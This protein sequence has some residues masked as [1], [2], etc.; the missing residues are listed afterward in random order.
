MPRHF[1]LCIIG[2]GSGNSILG[3]EFND[4]DVAMVDGARRWRASTGAASHRRC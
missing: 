3:P 4:W 2:T 1:D